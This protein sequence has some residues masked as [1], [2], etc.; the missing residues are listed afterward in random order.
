MP[1]AVD[2]P[3]VPLGD[4][5]VVPPT[6]QMAPEETSPDPAPLQVAEPDPMPEDAPPVE[7]LAK[8]GP[9]EEP[10]VEAP[11]LEEVLPE[12]PV[13]QAPA[14][15][16]EIP[17]EPLRPLAEVPPAEP[18]VEQPAEQP[19]DIEAPVEPVDEA[20]EAVEAPPLK[21]AK[22]VTLPEPPRQA[23]PAKQTS[24][25]KEQPAKEQVAQAAPSEPGQADTEIA[26]LPSPGNSNTTSQGGSSAPGTPGA[27]QV[28]ASPGELQDYG[29][30]LLGW[31]DR[32]KR[33]PD[34]ARK[35]RQEG[36]VTVELAVDGNGHLVSHRIVG[37]SG[38]SVL[39][40]EA[41]ELL[42]RASPFP[43]TPDGGVHSFQVPIVFALR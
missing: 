21:P 43:K 29:Q 26:S 7:Q 34:Q 3:P 38:V 10:A 35:R 32:H 33:Y 36:I 27:P 28:G 17:V 37:L 16:E 1:D 4:E 30:L 42:E 20:T 14:L 15:T 22:D 11:R 23:Q 41:R 5:Q 24:P 8:T 6:A 13:P 40:E 25:A 19:A 2:G 12:A 31:L 9:A 18:A 39:D